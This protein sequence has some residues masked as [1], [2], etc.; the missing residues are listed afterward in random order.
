MRLT[1]IGATGRTGRQLLRQALAVGHEVTAVARHPDDLPAGVRP[2]RA[3]LADADAQQLEP[4]LERRDAVLSALGPRS[5]A[6]A[7]ITTRGTTLVL[8]AMKATGTGRLVVVSAAPVETVPS[9]ARPDPPRRARGDGLLT[10]ALLMPIVRRAFRAT[11]AD[12][13]RMEDVVR[14]SE[15]TWTIVR[16]PRLTDRTHT[17]SYRTSADRNIGTSISRADLADCL[18]HCLTDPAT[19]RRI[20]RVAS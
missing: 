6:E 1:V 13:A 15:T 2:V 19:E 17:G 3:D 5:A 9:P 14:A 20:L 4:A 8:D 16:P 10:G 7:G 12:L 18:L 11:Y